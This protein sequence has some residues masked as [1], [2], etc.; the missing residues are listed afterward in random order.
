MIDVIVSTC[1]KNAQEIERT[2]DGMLDFC[3]D[4][5]VLLQYKRLCRYYYEINPINTA[6]YIN[7]YR[8]MW[9]SDDNEGHTDNSQ[10]FQ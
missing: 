10:E 6:F 8:E 5:K 4:S 9:D 1:S 7:S 3:F 2:L